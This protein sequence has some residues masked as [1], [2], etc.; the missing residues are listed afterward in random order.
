MGVVL[1]NSTLCI[2]PHQHHTRVC[3][4]H[5]AE[6]H[7]CVIASK[8]IMTA[9]QHL[10]RVSLRAR[11]RVFAAKQAGSAPRQGN[12]GTWQISAVLVRSLLSA[13]RWTSEMVGR[14]TS[15]G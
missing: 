14:L 7:T 10:H 13:V 2:C 11:A 3:A 1:G 9:N 15:C 4:A 6:T 8:G 5:G 12:M